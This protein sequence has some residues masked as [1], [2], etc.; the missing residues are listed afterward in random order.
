M[1]FA[2]F[3]D[4][5]NKLCSKADKAS[6]MRATS[7]LASSRPIK[8][9]RRTPQMQSSRINTDGKAIMHGNKLRGKRSS[10]KSSRQAERY[11]CGFR[12]SFT[13]F[14]DGI[15]MSSWTRCRQ[16]AGDLASRQKWLSYIRSLSCG[17]NLGVSNKS[18]P[19][20]SNLP[21]L[22]K[23]LLARVGCAHSHLQHCWFCRVATPHRCTGKH[24]LCSCCR[25]CPHTVGRPQSIPWDCLGRGNPSAGSMPS[26]RHAQCMDLQHP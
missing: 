12:A 24:P 7:F 26:H 6:S 8:S 25:H 21:R 2:V 4:R 19:W 22:L 3:A 20:K 16:D 23:G 15:K 18:C 5:N 11:S 10:S 9:S 17:T 13:G 14:E 1:S